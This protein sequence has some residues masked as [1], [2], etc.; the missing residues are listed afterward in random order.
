MCRH[1]PPLK[2]ETKKTELSR[3]LVAIDG[4]ETS[5]KAAE[6]AINLSKAQS[7]Q[8]KHEE[9]TTTAAEQLD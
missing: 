9:T 1:Y 6:Y 8:G 7:E 3:I 4:S 2:L 5:M